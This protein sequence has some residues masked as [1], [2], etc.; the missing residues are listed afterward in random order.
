MLKLKS[1]NGK[2]DENVALYSN[3]AKKGWKGGL[4]SKKNVEYYNCKKKGHYKTEC[5][6]LGGRKEGQGPNQRGK[7]KAKAKETTGMAK[8]KDEDKEKEKQVEEAWL[9]IIDDEN[10]LI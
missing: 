2:K 3:D 5:W 10:F 9:A 8:E 6:A 7:G 1:K 4:S